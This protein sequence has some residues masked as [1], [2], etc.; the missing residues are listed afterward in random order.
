MRERC[1]AKQPIGHLEIG[2]F[3]DA[4]KLIEFESNALQNLEY[5]AHGEEFC[6]S[7]AGMTRKKVFCFVR[8]QTFPRPIVR[9]RM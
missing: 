2:G 7:R 4:A 3:D 9:I 8:T 1:P 6:M 5:R